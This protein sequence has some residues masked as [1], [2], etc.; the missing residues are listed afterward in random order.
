[1]LGTVLARP[2]RLAGPQDFTEQS[3]VLRK[4]DQTL[5]ANFGAPES[6]PTPPPWR[7]T[8]VYPMPSYYQF[9]NAPKAPQGP[10]TPPPWVVIPWDPGARNNVLPYSA[11][12]WLVIQWTAIVGPYYADFCLVSW[13]DNSS[14]PDHTTVYTGIG[15]ALFYLPGMSQ[16]WTVELLADGV[17]LKPGYVRVGLPGQPVPP[18]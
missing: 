4:I 3:I 2:T 8:Q 16:A 11:W 10:T 12:D 7:T 17:R 18:W 5:R 13:G 15:I 14:F 6:K 1:M 9:I